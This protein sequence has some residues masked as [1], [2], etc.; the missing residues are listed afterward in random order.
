MSQF[1]KCLLSKL[2]DTDLDTLHPYK[3]LI[4]EE[5]FCNASVGES[6][7]VDQWN[8]LDSRASQ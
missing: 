2:G 3:K 6:D 7:M 5:H 1:I 8:S 4:S